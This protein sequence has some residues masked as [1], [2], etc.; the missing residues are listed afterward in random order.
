VDKSNRLGILKVLH[1]TKPTYSYHE[2]IYHSHNAPTMREAR[3]TPLKFKKTLTKQR[4][5]ISIAL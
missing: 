1:F 2:I 3:D 4:L 5:L